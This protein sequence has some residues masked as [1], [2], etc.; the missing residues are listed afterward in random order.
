MKDKKDIEILRRIALWNASNGG[1]REPGAA[2][3]GQQDKDDNSEILIDK[4]QRVN[5]PYKFFNMVYDGNYI[6]GAEAKDGA[7]YT[8]NLET[9]WQG[10]AL[11]NVGIDGE[12]YVR[13]CGDY[14]IAFIK[15]SVFM[16]YWGT[17][18][19]IINSGDVI[20][21]DIIYAGDVIY[22]L[23]FIN[24]IYYIHA[25]SDPVTV[26]NLVYST[27]E[28]IKW[29]AS[30]GELM[31]YADDR[32]VYLVTSVSESVVHC[33]RFNNGSGISKLVN[34]NGKFIALSKQG[35]YSYTAVYE[36]L[37]LQWI[38]CRKGNDKFVDCCFDG[39]NYF[40]INSSGQVYAGSPPSA[41][42]MFR[43]FSANPISI[44]ACGMYIVVTYPGKI[45]Y[46]NYDT[47]LKIENS[48][49]T[50]SSDIKK[51]LYFE[52]M[53]YVLDNGSQLYRG[54]DITNLEKYSIDSYVENMNVSYDGTR[55]YLVTYNGSNSTVRYIE[56]GSL[57]NVW[58]KSGSGYYDAWTSADGSLYTY[59]YSS[60]YIMKYNSETS[61]FENVVQH[62]SYDNKYH[63]SCYNP[64]TDTW[65]L[66][67]QTGW[68]VYYGHE[69]IFKN[70]VFTEVASERYNVAKSI[71]DN[72][73]RYSRYQNGYT[74][75]ESV[76][77]LRTDNTNDSITIGDINTC[78]ID[79]CKG[80][81]IL[82]AADGYIYVSK[83]MSNWVKIYYNSKYIM[84]SNAESQ[85][86]FYTN[87]FVANNK[88]F[89]IGKTK[90]ENKYSLYRGG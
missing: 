60:G 63:S 48:G 89:I 74:Y 79:Y 12:V 23:S 33:G 52:N 43:K 22:R 68:A 4:I 57:T 1:S 55:L 10:K 11:N 49:I 56:N 47:L 61:D 26:S 72:F 24:G 9:S 75:R 14:G 85:N 45:E 40:F 25:M 29:I 58:S 35:M 2:G 65:Y 90:G 36:D 19:G 31:M 17:T 46:L 34:L 86:G 70:N 18:S 16:E 64:Q 30:D 44:N 81:W 88:I 87:V 67:W 50:F 42:T 76:R 54:T 37:G 15:D 32:N 8:S 21:R 20:I 39:T 84:S 41:M 27:T 83:D 6:A 13:L 82:C 5:I 51:I 73:Y 69:G 62:N 71:G 7:Y 77:V 66:S 59:N 38:T 3:T 28:E 78:A 53:Y 80:Y